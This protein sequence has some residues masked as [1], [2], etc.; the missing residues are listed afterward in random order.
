VKYLENDGGDAA[1]RRARL[2]KLKFELNFS[3]VSP[4]FGRREQNEKQTA[5]TIQTNHEKKK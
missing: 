2:T 1:H 3:N 4:H 5:A